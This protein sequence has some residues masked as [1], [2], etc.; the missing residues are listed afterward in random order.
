[1]NINITLSSECTGENTKTENDLFT[2]AVAASVAHAYPDANV[3]VSMVDHF[4]STQVTVSDDDDASVSEH[5]TE[6]INH[7]WDRADYI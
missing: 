1:M 7:V 3:S 4:S 2:T 6:I 5:V